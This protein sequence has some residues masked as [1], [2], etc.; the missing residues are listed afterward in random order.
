MHQSVRLV[1]QD[2]V[3]LAG[4]YTA[5]EQP[6]GWTILVHM[7]PAAKES[8]K[9]F[10]AALEGAGIA[11]LAIDLRGHGAS[12][13]G[14]RGYEDFTDADHQGSAL[15]IDAAVAYLR[16]LGAA[17]ERIVLVGASIGAN[18][19]LQYLASHPALPA[20]VLLSPG[21]DYRGIA[22]KE[23]IVAI[24]RGRGLFIVSSQDDG[25]NA[26]EVLELWGLIPDG[27]TK[28]KRLYAHAG[29]GTAILEKEPSLAPA[30]IQFIENIYAHAT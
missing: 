27:V 2:G 18:L 28:E 3:S 29:H 4:T 16:T 15:D 11:S 26:Q 17:D 6:H 22:A 12:Q 23:Y 1:T 14:P 10:A 30:I 5:P 8:F 24:K 9:P 20:A 13:G 19:S 7:M 21:L 25:Y